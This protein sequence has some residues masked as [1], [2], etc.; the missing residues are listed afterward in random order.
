MQ[1]S[2]ESCIGSGLLYYYKEILA[3]L[4][5]NLSTQLGIVNKDQKTVYRIILNP[6]GNCKL[7]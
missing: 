4:L 2:D 7:F 6:E 5:T 3:W 1:D